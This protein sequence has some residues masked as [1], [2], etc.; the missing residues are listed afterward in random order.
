MK[1]QPVII[2]L[3]VSMAAMCV[4]TQSLLKNGLFCSSVSACI[5]HLQ[6]CGKCELKSHVLFIIKTNKHIKMVLSY[7]Y[8]HLKNAWWQQHVWEDPA[9]WCLTSLLT[10]MWGVRRAADG[11]LADGCY[12][13]L[14]WFRIR[15]AQQFWAFFLQEAP[16]VFSCLKVWT[17][18]GQFSTHE[19]LLWIQHETLI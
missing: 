4:L 3:P 7:Q 13:F 15:V 9:G 6:P 16:D 2:H 17:A 19:V 5:M 8:N 18:A 1:A 11:V 12:P 10:D 14:V